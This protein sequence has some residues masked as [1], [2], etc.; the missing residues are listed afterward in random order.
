MIHLLEPTETVPRRSNSRA[1]GKS[2]RRAPVP[3]TK[4]LVVPTRAAEDRKR[5]QYTGDSALR[6]YLSEACKEPLLTVNLRRS[7]EHEGVDQGGHDAS[8]HHRCDGNP[9]GF[10]F[11]ALAL[12]W[13]TLTQAD[14]LGALFQFVEVHSLRKDG[15]LIKLFFAAAAGT[16]GFFQ[17]GFNGTKTNYF[18]LS[19]RFFG[20]L[21][22]V[23]VTAVR[24]IKVANCDHAIREE[25]LTVMA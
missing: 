21:L 25:D 14:A 5:E 20:D 19:E 6:L 22:S 24:G 15:G 12:E 13:A 17:P 16:F 23:N 11:G 2:A 10:A 18:A 7:V 3:S 8:H 1:A 9:D 4:E